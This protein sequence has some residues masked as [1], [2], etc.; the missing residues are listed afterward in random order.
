MKNREEIL[1]LIWG[2]IENLTNWTKLMRLTVMMIET[3]YETCQTLPDDDYRHC[4]HLAAHAMSH[5]LI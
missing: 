4:G 2:P 3:H 1:N 5:K